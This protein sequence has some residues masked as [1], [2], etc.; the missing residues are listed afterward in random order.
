MTE[1]IDYD[2]WLP[3]VYEQRV[4]VWTAIVPLSWILAALGYMI[5]TTVLVTILCIW[6]CRPSKETKREVC[7]AQ[8]FPT[9]EPPPVRSS[10]AYHKYPESVHL[11]LAPD[12]T[13]ILSI[14]GVPAWRLGVEHGLTSG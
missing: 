2:A 6:Q 10:T 9:Y 8:P 14:D 11:H 12:H 3:V 13:K 7:V 4:G 5:V 1:A